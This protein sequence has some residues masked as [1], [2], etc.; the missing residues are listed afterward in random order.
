MM[1]QQEREKFKG[2]FLGRN[3][4]KNINF[5]SNYSQSLTDMMWEYLDGQ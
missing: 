2:F 4:K 3:F 5:I 1:N